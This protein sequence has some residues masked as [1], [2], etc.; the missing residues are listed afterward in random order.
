MKKMSRLLA[1]CLALLLALSGIV[2]AEGADQPSQEPQASE[3]AAPE[4]T[5]ALDQESAEENPVLLTMDGEDVTKATIDEMLANL[6]NNGYISSDKDYATA[7]EYW[8]QDQVVLAKIQELGL[9]QFTAEEEEAF[10]ADAQSEWDEAIDTYVSYF[11]SEDTDEAREKARAEGEA[12]YQAYGYSVELLAENLKLAASYEKLE[13][14]LLEGKDV[15]PTEEEIRQVFEEYAEQD[16]A[17]YE[18]NVYL[19][20]LYQNYG[21]ESWY[22]PAGY[23]GIL[24]I[25]LEVDDELLENYQNLQAAYEESL[26]SEESAGATAAPAEDG[27][28]PSPTEKPVTKEDV[29]A[30]LNAILD[31]RAKDIDDIY[32]RLEN[33]EAFESLIAEYGADPGMQNEDMLKS[34]YEVHQESIMWDPVFTAAAFSEKMQKPGDVS[35]PVVG[36]HGI[37]ILH[38]LRDIPEGYV[39]LGDDIRTQIESFLSNQKINVIYSEALEAWKGEHTIVYND[40]AIDAVSAADSGDAEG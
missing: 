26:S 39:E 12:Y 13:E 29:D 14:T 27:S 4:A 37:H 18:G 16:K 21:Q 33:G 25:L 8:I 9:D 20:E 19:Y 6:L 24:H 32:A 5:D 40:E 7:I 1:L 10:L 11:L 15:T 30:A 38:Y 36:S 28:T 2:L 23:R 17:L 22:M 31:S 3:T 35:D 34:G